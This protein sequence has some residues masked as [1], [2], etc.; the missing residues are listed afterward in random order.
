MITISGN[1]FQMDGQPFRILSG[2]MHYFR[3]H[4]D[5]WEDRLL[6]LRAM[7]LNTVE[8]Y[9]A[10]NLHEPRPGEFH[11]EN[12]LDLERYLTLAGSLGLKA[13]VRPGPYICSEWDFGGLPSWLLAGPGMRLRCAYSP[14]LV[15]V[16]R[17][18]RA[19]LP[20]LAP[21][22]IT[23]GGPVIAMQ[24]ENEYG[25]YGNDKNYLRHLENS[26]RNHG[27]DVLLFTS[28]G[29]NDL[30][31]QFGTLP[32]VFKSVN[33]GSG[34]V[35]AFAKLREYQPEGPLLC[36]EFWNGWFDHWGEAHHTRDPQ[37]A[38]AALDEILAL[39]ASVNLYMFHGGTNF[40]LMSGANEVP[41]PNY[42][43]TVTSYDDD[44]PLNEAG[45]PTPKY[46]AFREVLGR[47][48]TLPD[49]P[50]PEPSPKLSLGPVRLGESAGFFE[51]LNELSSPISSATPEPM[52]R[53]GFNVGFILYRTQVDAP[54][55]KASLGKA[56]LTI[57]ELHDRAQV[58]L[59]GNLVG[60]LEREFHQD[61][62][63]VEIPSNGAQI[64]ILVENMGRVNYGSGLADRKG[65]TDAVLLGQ[66]TL[67]DWKIYPIRLEESHLASL[68]FSPLR[69]LNGPA[70]FRG[71]FRVED[72]RD[73]FLAL[74]GWTKGL[75]W[76]NGFCL[77]R[78]WNRGPQKRLYLPAPLLRQGENELIVFEL[79]GT[80][81]AQVELVDQPDVG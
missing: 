76:I 39:G 58:F 65:I 6:K 20:R 37:D 60:V 77:G 47:Y 34:A 24:V 41:Y 43:A 80:E 78:Y 55:I 25:S 32:G 44:A 7:G 10:W 18:F 29:P 50:A 1:Q 31:L 14:Y 4:P 30:M 62:L 23:H 67:Y 9:V 22:Q 15:A 35:D 56:S 81:K 74:P 68:A 33:F 79:H 63:D 12:G 73:T 13:I 28:D 3:I 52:E 5:Y 48:T 71:T 64:D 11:F 2:A 19:L 8:T 72:P 40:G 16:D 57:R 53:L 54:G 38:A 75:A 26:L 45:D 59:K 46:F 49:L 69:S 70:F 36:A 66:Q 27:I 17:F 51:S 42:Q 61:S 21:L